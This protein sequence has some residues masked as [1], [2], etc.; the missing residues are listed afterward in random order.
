MSQVQVTIAAQVWD[1]KL[2][3][4]PADIAKGLYGVQSIPDSTGM[5]FTLASNVAT[6]NIDMNQ[7]NFPIDA[8]LID[9]NRIIVAVYHSIQN[10]NGIFTIGKPSGFS[11]YL[12]VNAGEALSVNA[13]ETAAFTLPSSVPAPAT[14]FTVNVGA[15]DSVT[16]LS[17]ASVIV[18]NGVSN[19]IPAGGSVQTIIQPL[20]DGS[21]SVTLSDVLP[22][23][24]TFSKW[25]DSSGATL[26][27]SNP[28]TLTFVAGTQIMQILAVLVG[29]SSAPPPSTPISSIID[30]NSIINLMMTMMIMK[31]MTSGMAGM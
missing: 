23:G 22:T 30:L 27:Q 24:V 15:L 3:S 4:L 17:V 21:F 11:S 8:I 19:T 9:V 31:V 28:V 26:S 18:V 29:A 25:I 13:G 1:S 14:T 5:L 16:L 6:V 10:G 2:A 12:L 20:T 7:M